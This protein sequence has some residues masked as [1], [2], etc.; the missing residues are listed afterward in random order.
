MQTSTCASPSPKMSR[1]I[2]HRREGCISS[3]MMKRN[4]TTPSSATCRIVAGSLNRPSP[5][6]PIA[7]PAAR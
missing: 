3:P 7:S 6:G 2:D 4:I 1:R 5:N